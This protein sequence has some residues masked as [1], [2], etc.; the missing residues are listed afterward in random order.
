MASVLILGEYGQGIPIALRLVDEGHIVKLGIKNAEAKALLEGY[1]N[2]SKVSNPKSLVDQYDLILSDTFGSGQL[3]DELK[4][5]KPVIGGS[6][7]NDKLMTDLKYQM[8]V[9]K[10]LTKMKLETETKKGIEVTTEGWFNG[11][12]WVRPFNHSFAMKRFM[13]G[14]IGPLTPCMGNVVWPTNGNKLTNE[15][16][17]LLQPLLEKV[18]YIGPISIH[19][20]INDQEIYFGGFTA[21]FNYDT[22]QAWCELL[23]LPL[24]DYLY[25]LISQQKQEIPFYNEFAMSVRLSIP[26]YPYEGVE[27][28]KQVRVLNIPKEAKKHVWLQDVMKQSDEEVLAAV[29]GV[30]GCVTARGQSVRECQRRAYRTIKNVV[31]C[32][33]V[34]YRTDVGQSAEEN[35]LKL[36]G[37]GW[38]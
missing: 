5:K 24:F 19:S 12:E 27:R 16:I 36:T 2:P 22:T 6:S 25:N 38:L 15:T 35:K 23:Q 7:F 14:D 26:P 1:R 10:T 4:E 9:V 21:G 3:C 33:D 8:K 32:Q 28:W 30:V 17:E 31:M 20:V 11:K 37:Q 18:G 29:D 13:T 34:Q